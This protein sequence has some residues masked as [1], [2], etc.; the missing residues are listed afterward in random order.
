M[1]HPRQE[2]MGLAWVGQGAHLSWEQAE[3]VSQGPQC[4]GEDS[5]AGERPSSFSQA[6]VLAQRQSQPEDG[7]QHHS[8]EASAVYVWLVM[9]FGQL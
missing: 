6:V 2:D 5:Q 9:F 8:R 7:A 1:V 4:P 3:A